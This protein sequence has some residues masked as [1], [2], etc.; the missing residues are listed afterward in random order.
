VLD[1]GAGGHG[2]ESR[3][4]GLVQEWTHGPGLTEEGLHGGWRSQKQSD[5]RELGELD[6][7]AVQVAGVKSAIRRASNR[8]IPWKWPKEM[9]VM[10]CGV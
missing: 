1:T 8:Y 9:A 6:M 2:P 5:W 7:V 3:R 4:R 10:W